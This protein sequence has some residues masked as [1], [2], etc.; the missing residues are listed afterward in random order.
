MPVPPPR[1]W[2]SKILRARVDLE[3]C[4][5][6]IGTG[7]FLRRATRQIEEDADSEESYEESCEESSLTER[8]PSA[9]T[10]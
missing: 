8:E 2:E 10:H 4:G 1:W 6:P 5:M 9:R 3:L 7:S